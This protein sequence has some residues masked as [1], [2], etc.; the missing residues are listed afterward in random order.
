MIG[1]V[2]LAVYL[3]T[4][5]DAGQ[6]ISGRPIQIQAQSLSDQYLARGAV[7][8]VYNDKN[9]GL[10]SYIPLKL[11]DKFKFLHCPVLL[12]QVF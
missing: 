6:L 3:M 2:A 7:C 9:N 1:L 4:P 5:D 11:G 8:T 12:F 10:A